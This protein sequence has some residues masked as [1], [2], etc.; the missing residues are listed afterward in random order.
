MQGTTVD[1]SWIITSTQGITLNQ[2]GA[3]P[4]RATVSNSLISAAGG[5]V[6]GAAQFNSMLRFTGTV[7]LADD[8]LVSNTS[9]SQRTIPSTGAAGSINFQ[10]TLKGAGNIFIDNEGGDGTGVGGV[11][12]TGNDPLQGAVCFS[13]EGAFA[14]NTTILKGAVTY[15]RPDAFGPSPSNVI[16]IGSAGGGSATLVQNGNG[17]FGLMENN[18]V[19]AAGSGGTIEMGAIGAPVS[20]VR[21]T[22]TNPG[23]TVTLND[24]LTLTSSITGANTYEIGDPILGVGGITKIGAG[25]ATFTN[26]ANSYSGP[27]AVN[28]GTLNFTASQT[29]SSAM[30]VAAGAKLN[31]THSGTHDHVI[32]TGAVSVDT[33][34]STGGTLD[35][36]DNK[37]ITTTP[38]AAVQAMVVSGQGTI[39]SGQPAWNGKGI[40]TSEAAAS[41][42]TLTTLA[43]ASAGDVKN[44]SGTTTA[45]WGGQTVHATDT[46]V[47]YTYGGDANL[48]GKIDADDFF[49]IDPNYNKSGSS[50]G[51]FNGDFNYD[52]LING[53]DYFI[54]DSN[55]ANQSLGTFPSA[56]PV[57]GLAAVPEPASLTGLALAGAAVF[58]RR[59]RHN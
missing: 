6:S 29:S 47:M 15:T 12:T 43:V 7:T 16:T 10:G 48:D 26:A 28:V 27:T 37:L 24:N 55:F 50:V 32:K 31:L 18:I 23:S 5:I 38:V 39:T 21:I 51:Y 58:A 25:N 45:T 22:S 19:I 13:E 41:S 59:R 53:D 46:L 30:T 33:T 49:R 40:I 3:G 9:N 17:S 1:H 52:G 11:K 35:L 54:I 42:S 20:S 36:A 14:G 2:D 8:L 57:G 56:A 34:P 44:I 4:G